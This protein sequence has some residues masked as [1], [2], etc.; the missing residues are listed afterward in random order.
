MIGLCLCALRTAGAAVNA[1]MGNVKGEA[2]CM[3]SL[4]DGNPV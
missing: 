3:A 1:Y 4:G 2:F